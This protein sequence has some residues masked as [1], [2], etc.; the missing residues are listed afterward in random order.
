MN[1]EPELK[2]RKQ[3]YD[4]NFKRPGVEHWLGRVDGFY[5][6][7]QRQGH[8]VGTIL[9]HQSRPAIAVKWNDQTCNHEFSRHDKDGSY[10]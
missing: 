2:V 8:I 4:L 9:S 10:C 5:A 1:N 6:A 7:G 3:R